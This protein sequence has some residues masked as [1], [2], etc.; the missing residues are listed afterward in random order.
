MQY[1]DMHCDTLAVAYAKK[2]KT[3]EHLE[4]AMADIAR[5]REAGA[6][7]QFFAMFLP[8]RDMPQW[9]GRETM[10]EPEA[11]FDGMY[12]I[13]QN[14]LEACSDALAP[15]RSYQELMQNQR[16]GRL[17]A[18]LTIENGYLAWGK[19]ENLKKF[20]DMGVRLI[21]L[22][23]NDANC[24]GYPHSAVLEEM[25]ARSSDMAWGLT[26]FGKEAIAYMGEL[27]MLIDVSHIADG[28]FWDVVSHAKQ[29]K[30][31]FVASHSNCRALA[32]STRNLTDEMIRALAEC[33]GVA[34][35]NF[36]PVFLN[37]DPTDAVSRVERMCDHVEHLIHVGGVECAGIGTDFDGIEGTFEISDC[38]G[39]SR[40]FD[41]LHTRGF[42]WDVIEKF[43]HSNVERVLRE[44]M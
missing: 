11:L 24:F 32:P 9:F 17:S 7:A 31:P 35:L 40:L 38:T 27:G 33:G 2:S 23:W 39:M 13:Y 28:G 1:I 6:N 44:V 3:A 4:G 20:Y 36:E 21:T 42:S 19:L 43:A 18:I 26:D 30:K 10:P 15:A 37:A 12:Q 34:G 29:V 41:A 8:Q 14:T 22:T 16:E 5:L 25:A